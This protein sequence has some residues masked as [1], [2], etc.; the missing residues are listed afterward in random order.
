M[1][2]IKDKRDKYLTKHAEKSEDTGVLENQISSYL[3]HK[4]LSIP[5]CK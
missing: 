3:V 2:M 5:L 4:L 1:N